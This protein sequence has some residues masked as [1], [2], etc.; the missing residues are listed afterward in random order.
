MGRVSPPRSFRTIGPL[1][2]TRPGVE[3][4]TVVRAPYPRLSEGTPRLIMRPPSSAEATNGSP[5]ATSS[6]A[7]PSS[8]CDD[9]TPAS[10]AAPVRDPFL[11]YAPDVA[12]VSPFP[13]GPR[14]SPPTFSGDIPV[15]AAI[16]RVIETLDSPDTSN[17]GAENLSSTQAPTISGPF[18]TQSSHPG[19]VAANAGPSAPIAEMHGQSRA[20]FFGDQRAPEGPP[21][22]HRP[23]PA[24]GVTEVGPWVQ[25]EARYLRAPDADLIPI[26]LGF[27]RHLHAPSPAP[28]DVESGIL[29]NPVLSP[30][31][32]HV[33]PRSSI[34]SISPGVCDFICWGPMAQADMLPSVAESVAVRE[35]GDYFWWRGLPSSLT[36]SSP[37]ENTLRLRPE[38]PVAFAHNLLGYASVLARAIPDDVFKPTLPQGSNC[39]FDSYRSTASEV[40]LDSRLQNISVVLPELC[41]RLFNNPGDAEILS[42]VGHRIALLPPREKALI[43]AMLRTNLPVSL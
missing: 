17:G 19:P 40:L 2:G 9:A 29:I 12:R 11:P 33:R 39:A 4:A 38:V 36:G 25:P 6:S 31:R 15:S 16:T 24:P 32:G 22:R 10:C 14:F 7:P 37:F 3:H 21:E 26:P 43:L 18:P 5:P 27:G 1:Q 35:G 13:H 8:A 30:R 23:V 20:P 34:F 42:R 41:V 28:E